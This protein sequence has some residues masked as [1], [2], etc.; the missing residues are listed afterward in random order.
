MLT[1]D[2]MGLSQDALN[3]RLASAVAEGEKSV[4]VRN[5]LG[6]RYLGTGL[7]P[8]SLDL[9][10]TP[11]EDLGAFMDGPKIR[12]FGNAQNAV[13]NTMNSGLIIVHGSAGD[14]VGHSMRGGQIWI[15]GNAGYR[16]GIHMKASASDGPII[17]IGGCAGDFLGEY[18]AGG[19][20]IVL[21]LDHATGDRMVGNWV[22][23]G[24]H[25]GAVYIR[26]EVPEYRLGRGA[27][28]GECDESDL[29]SLRKHLL[30][31]CREFN[32]SLREVLSGRFTKLSPVTS[33]PYGRLYASSVGEC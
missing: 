15:R 10:G 30:P 27:C 2:S 29:A 1:I 8:I 4:T 11:G 33:R 25:G 12:V 17:I 32:L 26:A 31:Y 14:I 5:V 7:P 21:G 16:V 20:L 6:Q 24:M 3:A 23:T 13:G 19:T 22:G 9:Y 18:M 28:Q